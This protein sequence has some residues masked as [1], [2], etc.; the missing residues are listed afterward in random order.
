VS[1]SCAKAAAH[2]RRHPI[3]RENC[4]ACVNTPNQAR[5]LPR[6]RE[7]SQAGARTAAHAPRLPIRRTCAVNGACAKT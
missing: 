6:M 1:Q 5:G 7:D 4:R 2:A 3:R